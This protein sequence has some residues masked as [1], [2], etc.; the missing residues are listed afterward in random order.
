MLIGFHDLAFC[1]LH[2]P[3]KAI[4]ISC[5][6]YF[7]EFFKPL[8][9]GELN[10]PK[11]KNNWILL[12]FI[13]ADHLYHVVVFWIEKKMKISQ[14]FCVF[15]YLQFR[16]RRRQLV[17]TRSVGHVRSLLHQSSGSK[18]DP[19]GLRVP[20][21]PAQ[22]GLPSFRIPRGKLRNWTATVNSGQEKLWKKFYFYQ[23]SELKIFFAIDLDE[24]MFESDD[25]T[26]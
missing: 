26:Y 10:L 4:L 16:V 15:C 17:R 5:Y 3:S 7:D 11:F 13:E 9:F 19:D 18:K 14:Q 1:S 8:Y 12:H 21:T 6:F 23:N 25:R 2:T 20:G 22:K 24:L